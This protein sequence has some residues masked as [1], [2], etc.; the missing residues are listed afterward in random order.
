MID[1]VDSIC[2]TY[3][4]VFRDPRGKPSYLDRQQ[5]I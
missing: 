1:A 4:F 3:A 2:K 5:Q